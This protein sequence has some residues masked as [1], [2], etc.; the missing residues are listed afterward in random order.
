MS[1]SDIESGARAVAL[2]V[3]H[4]SIPKRLLAFEV[5]CPRG[6]AAELV[7]SAREALPV[8]RGYLIGAGEHRIGGTR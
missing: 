4:L 1:I 7:I 5:T 2:V 6:N 8:I 3:Q